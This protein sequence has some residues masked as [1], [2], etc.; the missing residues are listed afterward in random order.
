M[1]RFVAN[2]TQTLSSNEG[3]E[4]GMPRYMTTLEKRLIQDC[5][6]NFYIR[7]KTVK[8]C[9]VIHK[10]EGNPL[11]RILETARQIFI[12]CFN[13]YLSSLDGLYLEK[14]GIV[15]ADELRIENG[16]FFSEL[17]QK[18]VDLDFLPKKV[19]R[20]ANNYLSIMN[21][22]NMANINNNA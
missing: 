11:A 17:L 8:Q 21:E 12:G 1:Q 7:V 19:Q 5:V 15:N 2:E 9:H 14:Y 4:T 16:Q 20:V 3:S 10:E 6:M 18:V 13:S 22:E